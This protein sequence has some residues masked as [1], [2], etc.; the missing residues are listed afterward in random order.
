[1]LSITR[2]SDPCVLMVSIHGDGPGFKVQVDSAAVAKV[3][4]NT[5]EECREGEG[6]VR[7]SGC[8]SVRWVWFY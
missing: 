6:M 3:I 4:A 1:M 7:F 2:E 5:I 8:G